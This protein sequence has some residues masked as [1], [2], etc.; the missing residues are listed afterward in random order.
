MCRSMDYKANSRRL[1]NLS[2]KYLNFAIS[3]YPVYNK[4]KAFFNLA[5]ESCKV[6]IILITSIYKA[7]FDRNI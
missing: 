6:G 3:I 7:Q 1:G 5:L 4:N 2:T